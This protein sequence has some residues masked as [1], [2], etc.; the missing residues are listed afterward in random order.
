M[1]VCIAIV[2]S[3]LS[4]LIDLCGIQQSQLSI[5]IDLCGTHEKKILIMTVQTYKS[6]DE[7]IF[8]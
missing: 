2:A 3:Q 7:I 6:I 8:F 1:L 4:I 5:L